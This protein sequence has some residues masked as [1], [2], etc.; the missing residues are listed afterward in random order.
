MGDTYK[1]IVCETD[2]AIILAAGASTR[3]GG[4][5][6]SMPLA[7]ETPVSLCVKAFYA[8]GFRRIIIT[9]G[10]ENFE[11]LNSIQCGGNINVVMGGGT[12]QESVLNALRRL[13]EDTRIVAVH[14]S[15]IHI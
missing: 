4:D 8:C 2:A 7:G 5:K 3:M 13:P 15:L 6:I 9:A 12:R 14:L 1:G 10:C 11:Y